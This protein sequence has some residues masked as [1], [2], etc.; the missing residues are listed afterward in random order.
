MVLIILIIPPRG[1]LDDSTLVLPST[2]LRVPAGPSAIRLSMDPNLQTTPLADSSNLKGAIMTCSDVMTKNPACCVPTDSV[3]RVAKIMKTQDVGS[4]PVCENQQNHKLIGIVTDRDLA[5]Q[6]VAEG[7]DANRTRVQD[8]MTKTP[9][10]CHPED[11][12]HTALEAMQKKQVR[13][14]PV[15]DRNGQ[16]VGIIAQADIATRSAAPEDTAKTVGEIS[17]HAARAA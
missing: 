10:T 4:V 12:I 13:R 6:V 14:V 9:F 15:V 1:R 11:D 16:L 3:S 17:K 7:H 2:E 8:V 5:L